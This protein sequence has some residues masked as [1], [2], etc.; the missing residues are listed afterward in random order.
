MPERSFWTL[1]CISSWC[2]GKDPSI[3]NK[4]HWK[5]TYK[6]N[7]AY[8]KLLLVDVPYA[9]EHVQHRGKMVCGMCF[10][11]CHFQST[12]P[13]RKSPFAGSCCLPTC[14]WLH[15][16][17]KTQPSWD[18]FYPSACR[19][20]AI[21]PSPV[22]MP[23]AGPRTRPRL[24]RCFRC[25][26]WRSALP[27]HHHRALTLLCRA[28]IGTSSLPCP[29][30]RGGR[31]C[32]SSAGGVLAK[33]SPG[34]WWASGSLQKWNLLLWPCPSRVCSARTGDGRWGQ[35]ALFSPSWFF[36]S[37]IIYRWETVLLLVLLYE[38]F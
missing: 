11:G 17:R 12:L 19:A 35:Q 5:K 32:M 2:P 34:L 13:W 33:G 25:C 22:L 4:H 36:P 27:Q 30:R 7:P 24:W 6:K 15:L 16:E 8:I 10:L 1:I 14:A 29:H 20:S 38:G 3:K 31:V 28:G 21:C 26:F 23:Q 37:Q 18:S 9:S